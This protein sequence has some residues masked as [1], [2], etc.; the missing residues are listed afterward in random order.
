MTVRRLKAPVVLDGVLSCPS[1]EDQ[2]GQLWERPGIL[3]LGDMHHGRSG[4]ALLYGQ[5]LWAG[6]ATSGT[7]VDKKD[8]MTHTSSENRIEGSAQLPAN[9]RPLALAITDVGLPGLGWNWPESGLR[10]R[11]LVPWPE[12]HTASPR[13]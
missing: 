4:R 7:S 1:Q 10:R 13:S 5:P 6:G 9:C 2:A 8:G 12:A 3:T 11:S